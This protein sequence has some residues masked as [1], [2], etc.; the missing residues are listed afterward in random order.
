ML[1]KSDGTVDLRLDL[2]N[3][4]GAL[5]NSYPRWGPLP[6]SD[7]LWLAFSSKRDYAPADFGLPQIWVSAIDT[8]KAEQGQDPSSA[9]FWLPGQSTMSDNHLPYWW[10]K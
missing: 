9:P 1:V 2:A 5:Q 4:E 10:G 3:G 6:D 7:V 8:A